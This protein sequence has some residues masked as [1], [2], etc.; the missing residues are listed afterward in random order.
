MAD[1][2]SQTEPNEYGEYVGPETFGESF[3][4]E[5]LKRAENSKRLVPDEYELIARFKDGEGKKHELSI[6]DIASIENAAVEEGTEPNSKLG[7][8]SRVHFDKKRTIEAAGVF[9]TLALATAV[10]MIRKKRK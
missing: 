7:I 5:L 8:F 9:G 2:D 4:G 10:I 1:A 6:D 3:H